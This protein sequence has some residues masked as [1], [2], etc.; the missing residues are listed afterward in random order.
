VNEQLIIVVKH[1]AEFSIVEAQEVIALCTRAYEEEFD[2]ILQQFED[3]THVLARLDNVLVSHA[4]WIPRTLVY[5]TIPLKSAYIE[6]VATEPAYQGRGFASKVMRFIAG[7]I[8]SFELGALSPSDPAFYT[9]LGWELWLGPLFVQSETG[10]ESTPEDQVMILRL[11][12]TPALDIHQQLTAPW[13][14]GEIW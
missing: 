9:R 13:R 7:Q 6:A 10:I 12:S 14:K 5:E 1:R 2:E 3:A 8:V 4:L 11:P